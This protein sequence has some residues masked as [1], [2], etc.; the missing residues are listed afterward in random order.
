MRGPRTGVPPIIKGID[1]NQYSQ[2]PWKPSVT[3][4][5]ILKKFK[6]LDILKYDETY[7]VRDHVMDCTTVVK[8]KE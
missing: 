4:L 2:Q 3:L 1:I 7:D 8:I 5:L 6:M